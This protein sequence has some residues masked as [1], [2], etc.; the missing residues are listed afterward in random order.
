MPLQGTDQGRLGR[1]GRAGLSDQG[2][3]SSPPG[4]EA[5]LWSPCTDQ[6]LSPAYLQP[7][8]I[9][10]WRQLGSPLIGHHQHFVGID[11]GGRAGGSLRLIVFPVAV[12]PQLPR[13]P[14]Q[15]AGP[16]GSCHVAIQRPQL[17]RQQLQEDPIAH[18]L[19][20]LLPKLATPL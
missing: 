20:W 16:L 10:T 12:T 11:L 7:H 19:A 2:G 9:H 3:R 4:R 5:A 6:R 14:Y 13:P 17:P 15:P 8:P 18:S 1:G